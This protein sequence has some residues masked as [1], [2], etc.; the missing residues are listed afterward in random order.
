[1]VEHINALRR[2]LELPPV[3]DLATRSTDQQWEAYL[4]SKP[5]LRQW[6]ATYKQQAE[7]LKQC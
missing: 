2:K 4:D 3:Q 6:A 1:M 7:M 5:G